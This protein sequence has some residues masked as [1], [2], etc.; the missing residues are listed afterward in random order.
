MD[1]APSGDPL[2]QLQFVVLLQYSTRYGCPI[3]CDYV[4]LISSSSLNS[5]ESPAIYLDRVLDVIQHLFSLSSKESGQYEW[6]IYFDV[7]A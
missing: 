2:E 6:F 4:P 3:D 7:N 5:D 1:L